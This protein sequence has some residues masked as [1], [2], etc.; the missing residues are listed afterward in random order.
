MFSTVG[1]LVG[2]EGAAVV[3]LFAGSGALGIEAL[4]RG[5]AS[6]TFVEQDRQAL[7]TIRAN[8][9]RLRLDGP[10]ARLHAG[11]ALAHLA[12]VA[13]ATIVLADPPYAFGQ[14]A[15]LGAGL[16]DNDFR[17]LAVLESGA[18]ID[19]GGGWDVVRVKRYGGTVVTV[20]RT[21]KG[22]SRMRGAR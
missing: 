6:V 5:A 15:Q 4:S 20:A 8:L 21:R 16:R 1:S 7:A 14:W 11:D 12:L 2:V 18:D 10:Q 17:G 22:P 13:D 3:D 9:A 19:L